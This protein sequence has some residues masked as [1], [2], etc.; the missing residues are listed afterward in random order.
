MATSFSF[1]MKRLKLSLKQLPMQTGLRIRPRNDARE[2]ALGEFLLTAAAEFAEL[3]G[4][5]VSALSRPGLREALRNKQ[6][7]KLVSEAR[8]FLQTAFERNYER[9][10]FD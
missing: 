2:E 9:S 6:A 4:G 10:L 5:D 8:Q 1:H 7:L 3:Q